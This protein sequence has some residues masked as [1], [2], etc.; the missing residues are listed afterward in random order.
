MCSFGA[1]QTATEVASCV[2]DGEQGAEG[3]A[4][5][6][7]TPVGGT[8]PAEPEECRF[9]AK[10]YCARGD[11]CAFKHSWER[12]AR[13][14]DESVGRWIRKGSSGAAKRKGEGKY[15]WKWM[16]AGSAAPARWREWGA[17]PPPGRV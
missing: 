14:A 17:T 5:C 2:S 10:G 15:V 4:G 13:G 3:L 7:N 16:P 9:F 6:A 12:D 1:A 11:K 8:E